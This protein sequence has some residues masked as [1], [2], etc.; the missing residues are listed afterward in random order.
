M[1]LKR[2]F[3]TLAALPKVDGLSV[4][5]CICFLVGLVCLSVVGDVNSFFKSP[6]SPIV[7]TKYLINNS[8]VTLSDGMYHFRAEITSTFTN[9]N[10]Y[11]VLVTQWESRVGGFAEQHVVFRNPMGNE[12]SVGDCIVRP[13]RLKPTE[14]EVVL[15]SLSYQLEEA[16]VETLKSND[17]KNPASILFVIPYRMVVTPRY[18]SGV[19]KLDLVREILEDFRIV[20]GFTLRSVKSS[21]TYGELICCKDDNPDVVYR[22]CNRFDQ[23][24]LDLA[25]DS[26]L[27]IS[28]ASRVIALI[29]WCILVP[30]CLNSSCCTYYTCVTR[31]HLTSFHGPR[32][33]STSKSPS[34]VQNLGR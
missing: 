16:V 8:P 24:S 33:L 3:D 19:F 34:Q 31:S 28:A 12:V 10:A 1:A 29:I 26:M 27:K 7:R 11:P 25:E 21:F 9:A 17:V 6:F 14:S 2:F 32:M 4:C 13:V 15:I 20:C 23:K 30:C 22:E 18:T 5:L